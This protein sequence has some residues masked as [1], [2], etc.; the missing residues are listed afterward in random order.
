[1]GRKRKPQQHT[2]SVRISETLRDYLERAREVIASSK[3]AS[4]STSDV[5]KMLLELAKGERLD[6]RL[7]VTELLRHPT[8]TLLGIRQK[9]EQKRL[10]SRAEWVVLAH[11]LQIGC[12]GTFE[13]VEAAGQESFAELLEAFQALLALRTGSRANR[14]P[15]YLGNIGPPA[16]T[17]GKSLSDSEA[18]TQS[19]KQL[20]RTLREPGST[21]KP[22]FAGRNFYVAIRD[23]ELEDIA[24]VNHAL[25]QH[26]PA[27][28][29]FAARGHWLREQ[30]PIRPRRE[31]QDYGF[32]SSVFPQLTAGDFRLSILL[33]AEEDLTMAIEMPVRDVTY[34]LGFYPQIREFAT[35]LTR[36]KASGHWKGR[37]FFG[38]TNAQVSGSATHFY[39]RHRS[40]GIAFGFTPEA[41]KSLEAMFAKALALPELQPAL[42]ELV[43]QYGEV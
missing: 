39:F 16:V 18:V 35:M 14:D 32:R 41:W 30:R 12:E 9:W 26:M 7:E 42:R 31:S 2:L 17:R 1:M 10:I 15:Y 33:S 6:D 28:F 4:V 21:T 23:E 25:L 22:V 29:R 19:V 34:P 38:Y 3:G 20:I 8:E 43:L 27:L 5:A 37:E 11:Y 13:D 40:N 24:A 36:V